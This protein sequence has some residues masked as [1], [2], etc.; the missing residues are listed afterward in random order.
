METERTITSV[1]VSRGSEYISVTQGVNNQLDIYQLPARP[2]D[3][4]QSNST[5]E[6]NLAQPTITANST[7]A[8]LAEVPEGDEDAAVTAGDDEIPKATRQSRQMQPLG[9]APVLSLIPP[10][11]G[12]VS[13]PHPTPPPPPPPPMD[14][15]DE[16][17]DGCASR[18]GTA[19]SSK[20]KGGKSKPGTAK[21]KPGT[22]KANTA[23]SSSSTSL[24]TENE[25]FRIRLEKRLEFST[26]PPSITFVAE[27]EEDDAKSIRPIQRCRIGNVIVFWPTTNVIRKYSL[28]RI[29]AA[30]AEGTSVDDG[31]ADGE[32]DE[33]DARMEKLRHNT[34]CWEWF[35]PS[36][37]TTSAINDGHDCYAV[38]TRDGS[39]YVLMVAD[40]AVRCSPRRHV[41]PKGKGVSLTSVSLYRTQYLITGGVDGSVMINDLNG[42][43]LVTTSLETMI[44]G[45]AVVSQR[46]RRAKL[47]AEKEAKMKEMQNSMF[48]GASKMMGGPSMTSVRTSPSRALSKRSGGSR[49]GPAVSWQAN[50]PSTC[51]IRGRIPY[52]DLTAP[53]L[54]ICCMKSIPVAVVSCGDGGKTGT[55]T[56]TTKLYDLTSGEVMGYVGFFFSKIFL[57][58]VVMLYYCT[59]V[60]LLLFFITSD[61]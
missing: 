18:V 49:G 54:D 19:A 32:D 57:C 5:L 36:A 31:S 25:P 8:K 14:D 27:W 2:T 52:E 37:I 4:S 30:A 15:E 51:V 17:E 53:V 38:G 50:L 46:L 55:E 42:A 61:Y 29:T 48:G 20:S 7:E 60:A 45:R 28:V 44:N 35:S 6:N 34:L 1:T 56:V 23:A 47:R 33:K 59:M 40:G 11:F 24:G 9:P 13:L 43:D 3:S 39:C 21:S 16:T 22:S 41:S 26:P 12:T 58:R 10:K